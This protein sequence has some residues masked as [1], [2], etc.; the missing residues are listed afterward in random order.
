MTPDATNPAAGGAAGSGNDHHKREASD[1]SGNRL[2]ARDIQ[3]QNLVRRSG[4]RHLHELSRQQG[5]RDRDSP[6]LC[7]SPS[8]MAPRRMDE[9]GPSG[10]TSVTSSN[11]SISSSIELEE[12][13]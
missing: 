13:A 10:W 2:P 11:W 3:A 1:V 5:R 7:G 8:V 9:A 6:L 12:R 4:V